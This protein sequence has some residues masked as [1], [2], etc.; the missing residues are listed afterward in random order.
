MDLNKRNLLWI[1]QRQH[2]AKKSAPPS[3]HLSACLLLAL[4]IA[5]LQPLI[6]RENPKMLA[7]AAIAAA[8]Q[9]PIRRK[10]APK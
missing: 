2:L 7:A 3:Y 9:K 10:M 1:L 8:G 6:V 4:A 5:L